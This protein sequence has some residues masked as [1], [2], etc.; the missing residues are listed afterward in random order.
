MIA[1]DMLSRGV[2]QGIIT[3]E[4]AARLQTLT[5][6]NN[7]L[8]PPPSP[9][10]EHIRFIG[11]FGDIFVTIG[12]AMFAGASTYLISLAGGLIGACAWGMLIAWLLA[13]FF[14]RRR[15]MA[16]PSIVLLVMFTVATFA[17]FAITADGVLSAVL[18]GPRFIISSG[19]IEETFALASI[20]AVAL[21]VAALL[22]SLA[23]ALHYRRF[24]VPI[25][26][27]AG[28]A[29]MVTAL[30][31]LA[32]DIFPPDSPALAIILFI[33]GLIIFAI[34][35]R[36][37][38]SD[39]ARLTRKTDIAFWLHL[40]AA[41]MIVH[42]LIGG[43]TNVTDLTPVAAGAILLV[44]MVIGFVAVLIDR[45]ALLVSGLT[46]AGI[47]FATL[48]QATG[49]SGITL[50]ATLVALGSFILLLSA[51]WR[52]LRKTIIAVAP[53]SLARRLPATQDAP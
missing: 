53:A 15:R 9:D 5:A 7:P 13:E 25:T 1:G 11:G 32:V 52:S 39:P 16:L 4:Q 20:R 6:T 31:G 24:R 10:D 45:R 30:W 2:R 36:F 49:F 48:I 12:I 46:Y 43:Y 51:G 3:A 35:M 17:F 38:M 37:D 27:A 23:V 40:L 50:P 14:T 47:A 42:S 44:F 28:C 26:L 33:C 41:P 18:K 22:T 29:V 34:A 19:T 8:D 21:I